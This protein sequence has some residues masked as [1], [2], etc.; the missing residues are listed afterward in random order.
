VAARSRDRPRR[1]AAA[2]AATGR[3][4]RGGDSLPLPRSGWAGCVF[5]GSLRGPHRQ[6]ASR[7]SG[8]PRDNLW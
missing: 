8:N 4:A 7:G 2:A 6:S 5:M 1:R 3:A